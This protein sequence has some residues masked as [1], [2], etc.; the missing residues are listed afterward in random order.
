MSVLFKRCT[1]LR[2]YIEFGPFSSNGIIYYTSMKNHPQYNA[3]SL[4]HPLYFTCPQVPSILSPKY[5]PNWS[6]SLYPTAHSYK[7][8]SIQASKAWNTKFLT[9]A[10]KPILICFA[11]LPRRYCIYFLFLFPFLLFSPSSHFFSSSFPVAS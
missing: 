8:I 4:S 9:S 11:A 2:G 5:L 10:S 3:P 6:A 7:I 1:K